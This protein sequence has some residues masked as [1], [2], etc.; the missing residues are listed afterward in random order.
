[1]AQTPPSASALPLGRAAALALLACACTANLDLA[2]PSGDAAAD[3]DARASDGAPA[4]LGAAD[5]ATAP[6][7]DDAG[8]DQGAGG[9]DDADGD[10][11]GDGCALGADCDDRDPAVSP[12]APERCDGVDNTCDGVVDEGFEQ[13]GRI[14]TGGRGVCA[15]PGM[16][17][18]TPDGAGVVC[19]VTPGLPD[20]EICNGLDDDCD[21]Q[22]DEAVDGCCQPGDTRACGADVG[23]CT[24]GTQACDGDLMRWA[25]CSGTGP[26]DEACD[27]V[28]QDCDGR[29]DEGVANACGACGPLPDEACDGVDNDCDG[30]VDEGLLNACGA[31]GR[32]P[33]ERCDALDND[34]D[35][36][37]DEGVLNAC[38][39]CGRPPVETC[40]GTDE[41]CDG[42][43]DDGV[44]APAVDACAAL[45]P[46]PVGQVVEGPIGGAPA[47]HAATCGADGR[48]PEVAWQVDLPPVTTACLSTAGSDFDTVL[49]LR[50]DCAD[51]ASQF[52]CN[53]DTPGLG[54]QSRLQVDTGVY[55]RFVVFV[56]SFAAS[57]PA[58]TYRL[59]V[60]LGP[61]DAP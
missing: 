7:P 2:G 48:G 39:A 18:C 60:T 51:A 9:C 19:Q 49:H 31:C 25:A 1:M 56:D 47:N 53:D 20:D 29:T 42:L 28:D 14:C 45:A 22:A 41:D 23:A 36:A 33:P 21:G 26:V 38:G 32:L 34:C 50:T 54:L 61:C 15:R 43:V 52:A 13:A 44:C 35:G 37:V 57:V 10:G 12:G 30:R 8:P 55:P 46:L 11:F 16:Y 5:A 58:G 40:D 24:A 3:G 4:D 6:K 59:Q 17:T 27:G